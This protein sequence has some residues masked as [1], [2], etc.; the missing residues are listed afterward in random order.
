[1]YIINHARLFSLRERLAAFL[2][3]LTQIET[4]PMITQKNKSFCSRLHPSLFA[5]MA[6]TV[7]S[8]YSG[9]FEFSTWSNFDPSVGGTDPLIS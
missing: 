3:D 2:R 5:E 4:P 9:T 8:A 7:A 1:M 6:A